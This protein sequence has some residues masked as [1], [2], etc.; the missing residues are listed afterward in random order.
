LFSIGICCGPLSRYLSNAVC[1]DL[2]PC[3][4]AG[5]LAGVDSDLFAPRYLDS[6]A[7]E[8][9]IHSGFAKYSPV[10]ALQRHVNRA[11][12]C[13]GLNHRITGTIVIAETVAGRDPG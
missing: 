7:T 2:L 8:S 3:V 13:R 9:M 12:N 5:H 1:N 10:V 4:V 11:H 6:S